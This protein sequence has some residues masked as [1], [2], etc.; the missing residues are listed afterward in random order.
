MDSIFFFWMFIDRFSSIDAKNVASDES[1]TGSVSGN[2][3]GIFSPSSIFLSC[4]LLF[5]HRGL[6]V[7]V[8]KVKA[9]V[10]VVRHSRAGSVALDTSVRCFQVLIRW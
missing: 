5:V 7:V 9:E 10:K 3:R 4:V 8:K 2:E 1:S 6:A